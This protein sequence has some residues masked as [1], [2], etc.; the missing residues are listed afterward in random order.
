MK[1][2]KLLA[3]LLGFVVGLITMPIASFVWPGVCAWYLYH[4]EDEP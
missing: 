4:E 2:Q 3:G 1:K